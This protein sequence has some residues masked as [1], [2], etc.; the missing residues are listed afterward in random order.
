MMFPLLQ[1]KEPAKSPATQGVTD[2]T[3]EPS[4]VVPPVWDKG[5]GE[6][7]SEESL[8]NRCERLRDS[9]SKDRPNSDPGTQS[10]RKYRQF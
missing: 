10:I 3:L 4:D 9:E 5:N 7:S 6:D 8:M 1:V 2:S